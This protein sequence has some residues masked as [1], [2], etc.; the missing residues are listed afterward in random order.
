MPCGVPHGTA[1]A[2]HAYDK[3]DARAAATLGGV[4]LSH[5]IKGEIELA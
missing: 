3:L 2:V 4:A 5:E 1:L